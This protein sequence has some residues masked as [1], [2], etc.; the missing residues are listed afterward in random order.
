M[1]LKLSYNHTYEFTT[2]DYFNASDPPLTFEASARATPEWARLVRNWLEN[3]PDDVGPA[4][5]IVGRAII[6]VSQN[7][8]K[9]PINGREGAK[10]LRDAIEQGNPGQGDDFIIDLAQ[11]HY[12]YH[13][14]RLADLVGNSDEPS[15]DYADGNNRSD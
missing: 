6:S 12:N 13:F 2:A 9:Y 7:G 8:T 5:E 4:L 1:E 11:G 15:T 3:S 14:R 10:A